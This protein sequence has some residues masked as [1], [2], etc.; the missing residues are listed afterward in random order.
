MQVRIIKGTNQIGGTITEISEDS[1]KIIIDFGIDLDETKKPIN[2]KGLTEGKSTYSAVFITH[3]HGD[4]IGL[5]D[6]I[7]KDIPIYVEEKSLMIH[8]LTCDFCGK[9]KIRRNINTFT[10]PKNIKDSKPIFDNSDIAV[11]PLYH[12]PFI[13]QFLYVSNRIKKR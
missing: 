11:T 7:N 9:E 8:N 12:R 13:I 10:L 3:S 6:K 2:I 5:I 4:H 1:T